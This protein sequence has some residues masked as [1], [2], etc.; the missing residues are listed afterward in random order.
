VPRSTLTHLT[1]VIR[2]TLKRLGD[3]N[4]KAAD[5]KAKALEWFPEWSQQIKVCKNWSPYVTQN[6]NRVAEEL[7]VERKVQTGGGG[8]PQRGTLTFSDYEIKSAKAA[9]QAIKRIVEGLHDS[10]VSIVELLMFLRIVDLPTIKFLQKISPKDAMEI[11]KY[12]KECG[13]LS[14]ITTAYSL[15]LKED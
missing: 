3:P 12:Q 13:N 10:D 14:V 7:G 9:G 6:R 5:V 2:F 8:T 11:K 15:G 1:E 4:A